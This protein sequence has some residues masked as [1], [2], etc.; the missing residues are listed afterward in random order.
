M[1]GEKLG[2]SGFVIH[3]LLPSMSGARH[4]VRDAGPLRLGS[5][6]FQTEVEFVAGVG[7]GG[8]GASDA[9]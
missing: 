7:V 6:G 1:S 5:A 2:P 4:R 3:D 9:V 8:A